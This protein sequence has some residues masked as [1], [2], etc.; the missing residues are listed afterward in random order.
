[1]K[2]WLRPNSR[3]STCK[4]FECWNNIWDGTINSKSISVYKT[5]GH[6]DALVV[7]KPLTKPPYQV[8]KQSKRSEFFKLCILKFRTAADEEITNTKIPKPEIKTIRRCGLINHLWKHS[9]F[10]FD[11]KNIRLFNELS[12]TRIQHLQSCFVTCNF[13]K[14]IFNIDKNVERDHWGDNG[15]NKPLYLLLLD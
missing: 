8:D 12:K 9:M 6:I 5:F 7:L 10:F 2:T 15:F 11:K 4:F 13:H 1:M 14:T 3:T